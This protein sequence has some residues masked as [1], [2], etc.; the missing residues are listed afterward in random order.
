M[1]TCPQPTTNP[2]S[3]IRAVKDGDLAAIDELLKGPCD[4]EQ[5]GMWGNTPLLAACMNDKG[6][7]AVRLINLGANIAAMNE[8]RASPLHFATVEGDLTVVEA[9]I[10]SAMDAGGEELVRKLVNCGDAKIYNRH[11]DAYASRTPVCSAAESGFVDIVCA[12]VAAGAN[13]EA[14]SSEDGRTALWLACSQSRTGI[15][16][17]LLQTG[18]KANTKDAFGI[19]ALQA[20][21]RANR[22]ESEEAALLLLSHGLED[23]ND[24]AGSTLFDAVQCGKRTVVE[25]LLTHGVHVNA[26][27][28]A[29]KASSTGPLH[30]ACER[31]DEH[32][33]SLL[34]RARA[35]PSIADDRGITALDMLRRRGLQDGHIMSLLTPPSG[36][37]AEAGTGATGENFGVASGLSD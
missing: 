17:H 14:C 13:T 5:E 27:S 37:S 4:I 36:S 20:A 9:I 7:V 34:V 35:D 8:N 18:A 32:L 15:A 28:D 24:T 25:A 10:N 12:L 16:R 31:G 23:V 1:K 2:K 3:L 29:S 26:S 22:P 33:I 6:D 19:S 11:L 30:A 21:V